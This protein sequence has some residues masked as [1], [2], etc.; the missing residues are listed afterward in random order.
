MDNE[1]IKK[2]LQAA[3]AKPAARPRKRPKL[4]SFEVAEQKGNAAFA[5][6]LA[7]SACPYHDHRTIRGG[8]TF[9]RAYRR[10]WIKGYRRAAQGEPAAQNTSE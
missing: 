1:T 4:D 9:A 2:A 8:V 3:N 5:A 10:A 7:E 6:G